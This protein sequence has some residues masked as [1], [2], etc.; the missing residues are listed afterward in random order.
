MRGGASDLENI[1]REGDVGR[2]LSRALAPPGTKR[3]RGL[4][5][6]LEPP[7]ET[8]S[9]FF[10]PVGAYNRDKRPLSP[11]WPRLSLDPGQKLPIV[12]GPKTAGTNGL[13]QRP[14]L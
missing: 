13:E 8:K 6:R 5:S 3:P 14:V 11:H 7:P 9:S 1:G 10:V 12:P 4:L 2:F